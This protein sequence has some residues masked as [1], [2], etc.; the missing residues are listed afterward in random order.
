MKIAITKL[1]FFEDDSGAVFIDQWIDINTEWEKDIPWL[2][3]V[4]RNGTYKI[5]VQLYQALQIEHP[6]HA[7]K[8]NMEKNQNMTEEVLVLFIR[9]FISY[10]FADRS[11]DDWDFILYSDGTSEIN[12]E[13]RSCATNCPFISEIDRSIKKAKASKDASLNKQLDRHIMKTSLFKSK[14][15]KWEL[16]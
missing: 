3:F 5:L 15:N 9:K 2:E 13:N 10:F 4:K 1:E 8:V 14:K 11:I 12:L 7:E 6:Y 16:E